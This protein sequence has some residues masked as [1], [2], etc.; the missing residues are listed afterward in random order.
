MH[1]LVKR[2]ATPGFRLEEVPRPVPEPGEVLIK[3]LRTGICGTDLHIYEWDAWAQGTVAAPLVVGH[4]FVGEVV[5]NASP[6]PFR[7]G[8]LVGGESHVVCNGCASCRAGQ[9]HLCGGTRI[10]GV[11][12]DGAFAEYLALPA[13]NVWR[14]RD[15]IDLDVAAIFD[16]FGNAVH[17]ALHFDLRDQDVLI[18][19]AGPIGLM[20]GAVARHTGARSVAV[21]DVSDY[22][23]GLAD[24]VGARPVRDLDADDDGGPAPLPFTLGLEMSGSQAG[25]QG[26]L[27]HMAPGGRVAA[28]GLASDRILLDWSSVVTKMLTV[29]GIF[30]RRIFDT[31]DEMSRLLHE[32]LDLRPIITHRFDYHDYE[33]AF[34]VVASRECGKVILEWAPASDANGGASCG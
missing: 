21:T 34:A 2:E 16:P 17:A 33:E 18:A 28:L 22:R 7:P 1:A 32:G 12:R 15:R 6:A 13:A 9:P 10:I 4:E 31:W 3:V 30:G 29:Q 14:H 25:L 19:G 26:M 5:E 20:A 11:H 24:A 8:D 23:L 27:G